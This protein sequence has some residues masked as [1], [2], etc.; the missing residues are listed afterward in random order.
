MPTKK[1]SVAVAKT[2]TTIKV[3]RSSKYEGVDALPKTLTIS[4]A[5]AIEKFKTNDSKTFLS[6]RR[7]KL[8]IRD[9][10]KV[11]SSDLKK[12]ESAV[13]KLFLSRGN[14]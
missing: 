11:K 12:A 5:E 1:N 14:K 7:S 2:P 8:T 6:K 4:T 13:Q 10:P 9:N 3:I